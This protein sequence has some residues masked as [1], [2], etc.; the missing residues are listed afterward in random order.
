LTGSSLPLFTTIL[1]TLWLREPLGLREILLSV[2]LVL[3]ARK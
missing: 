3:G 1:S 2:W